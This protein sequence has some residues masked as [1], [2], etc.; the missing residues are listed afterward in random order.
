[1]VGRKGAHERQMKA[2]R[3]MRELGIP[4]RFNTVLT[5][6]VICQL[7]AIARL[8]VRTGALCVNWLGYNPHED[9]LGKAK[10]WN[11]I[12]N[13][14]ELR[15]PLTEALDILQAANIETNVRYM[16]VCMVEARHRECIYDYQQLFY[17]HREWDLASWGWTTLPPQR[18]SAGPTSDPVSVNSLAMWVRLHRPMRWVTSLPYLGPLLSIKRLV[19]HEATRRLLL[20]FQRLLTRMT[21]SGFSSDRAALYGE[22]ARLH[23][24]F[25]CRMEF[26]KGCHSCGARYICSG[27]LCDYHQVFGRGEVRPI[28]GPAFRDALHYIRNQNKLVETED[29]SWALSMPAGE[30]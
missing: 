29:E 10:R 3:N 12:P 17:D 24:R 11:L 6:S 9:Q 23:A 14:T 30:E 18:N 19:N 22:V 27:I 15:A 21:S 13:F 1:V 4:F 8:A 2:I 7:P 20:Q 16:P 26:E 28:P 25:D 5:P